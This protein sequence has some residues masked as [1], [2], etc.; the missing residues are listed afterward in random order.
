MTRSTSSKTAGF[1]L[2]FYI[3]VGITSLMVFARASAG[4]AIGDKLAAIATHTSAIGVTVL[5]ELA[6]SLCAIV[7][8]VTFYAITRDVDRDL[9]LLGGACR[10]VEGML[11]AFGIQKTL[12]LLWLATASGPAAPEPA[13][14]QALGAYLSRGSVALSATF[15][16]L[17]STLFAFL[18][19]RG[20]IVPAGLAGLG[21]AA[22]LLLVVVMP[23]QLAGFLRSPLAVWAWLPMVAFEVPLG[24]WLLVKGARPPQQAPAT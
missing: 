3:V 16:A 14:A 2:L 15:F 5:L 11:G 21:V 7:L 4:A 24:A 9:A 17:G 10:F 23:L 8:A 1:T 6:Q 19:L 12:G 18:L 13:A 20:R 22:S